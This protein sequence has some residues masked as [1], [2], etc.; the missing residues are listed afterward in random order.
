MSV[1]L[2]YCNSS[3]SLSLTR[4]L[5]TIITRITRITRKKRLKRACFERYIG[6]HLILSHIMLYH[7]KMALA[8]FV[9]MRD[10]LFNKKRKF[11]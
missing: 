8:S 4:G 2:V 9:S 6:C 3:A 1:E 5:G 10:G 7:F 11:G